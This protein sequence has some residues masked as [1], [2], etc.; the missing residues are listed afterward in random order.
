MRWIVLGLLGALLA[1]CSTLKDGFGGEQ[2]HKPLLEQ[3]LVML[4][5]HSGLVNQICRKRGWFGDCTDFSRA[6]YSLDDAEIRQNLVRLSFLCKVAGKHYR[7]NP[8]KAEFIRYERFR[9]CWLCREKTEVVERIPFEKT[10]FLI[11]SKTTC[12]SEKTYPD[13]V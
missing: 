7:V 10:Q 13:G 9:E 8:D 11:D 4:P 6:E 3:I 1:G 5:G 2:S 12:W